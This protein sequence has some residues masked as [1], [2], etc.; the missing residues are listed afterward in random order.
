VVGPDY[1]EL[2]KYAIRLRVELAAV[3]GSE[4]DARVNSINLGIIMTPLAQTELDSERDG[5]CER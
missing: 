2:S 3:H 4:R 5:R 1:G